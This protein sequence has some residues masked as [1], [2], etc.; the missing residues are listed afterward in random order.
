M[1]SQPLGFWLPPQASTYAHHVDMLYWFIFWIS[2][3]NF[4]LILGGMGYLLAKYRRRGPEA[5]KN[6]L[7]HSRVL[8]L[9]WTIMPTI[10]CVIIFYWGFVGFMDMYII[11]DNTYEVRV[12]SYKWN[13]E[14]T[15]PESQFGRFPTQDPSETIQVRNPETGEIEDKQLPVLY[16]E[17]G[18]PV[19]LVMTSSDVLHAVFIPAFRA[20]RDV[21]PGRYNSMWFEPTEEGVFPLYC[22]EYCGDSHWAMKAIVRV[23]PSGHLEQTLA[24]SYRDI[25]AKDPAD[26]GE[27]LYT[28]RGCA[29]CHSIDGTRRIGPSFKGIW[30]ERH[31]MTDGTVVEVDENYVLESIRYPAAKIVAGYDNR[32]PPYPESALPMEEVDGLI[33]FFKKL[34]GIEPPPAEDDAEDNDAEPADATTENN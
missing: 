13:W 2:V 21:V 25:I 8:E 17:V 15:Y 33:A 29:S 12:K 11:P 10:I 32:M 34:S 9:T 1:L 4:V 14:F 19:K 3:V 27:F 22:A 18:T 16:V 20:K 23:L 30:G 7:E 26:F 5:P 24:E 28:A 6:V 31:E